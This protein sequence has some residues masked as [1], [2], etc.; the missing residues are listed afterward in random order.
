[1]SSL[2]PGGQLHKA[3]AFTIRREGVDRQWAT[4]LVLQPVFHSRPSADLIAERAHETE[5]RTQPLGR[6][7]WEDSMQTKFT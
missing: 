4:Y 3:G 5:T 6:N 2:W 1:M 7:A